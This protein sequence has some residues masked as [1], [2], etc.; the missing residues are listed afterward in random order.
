MAEQ[1]LPP[2]AKSVYT[3]CKKCGA[4]RYHTVLAHTSATSAKVECETCH[5]KK[6]Y[7]LPSARKAKVPGA[8]KAKSTSPRGASARAA[9]HEQ[10]YQTLLS[11]A[12]TDAAPYNM[13]MKFTLNQK[14]QHPKFGVGVVK[15]A[16][17][18]KVE[19]VFQDEVRNL[20]HNRG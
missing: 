4:E 19:V 16:F 1:T 13:K 11:A 5:S 12:P 2:V 9:A 20:V 17:N 6:T 3:D 14:I 7:K 10:E 8:P 18:D 15:T